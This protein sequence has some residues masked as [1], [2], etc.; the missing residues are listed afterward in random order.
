MLRS[1]SPPALHHLVSSVL[2]TPAEVSK[3]LVERFLARP[4]FSYKLL[5]NL[6]Q[7]AM[8][9]D[10]SLAQFDA[11]VRKHQ[12]PKYQPIFLEITPL[13]YEHFGALRPKFVL[14]VEP[15]KYLINDL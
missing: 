9:A 11:A 15:R 8:K 1:L 2:D 13:I 12:P 10:A 14:P 3:S 6:V 7:I 5:G 4:P